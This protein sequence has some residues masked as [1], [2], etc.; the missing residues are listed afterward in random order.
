MGK[1]VDLTGK[2]F[3]RWMVMYRA[4]NRIDADGKTRVWFHCKCECGK[5]AD[6]NA[7]SLRNGKS[8]SCGCAR[9]EH[10]RGNHANRV[11]GQKGTRLYSIWCNMNDRCYRRE[12]ERYHRYGGRGIKVCDEWRGKHGFQSFMEWAYK[13]GYSKALTL[14]RIDNDRG[15]SPQNCRWASPKEQ[16]NNRSNGRYITV[17]EVRQ[18]VAQWSDQL[19]LKRPGIY[20]KSDEEIAALIQKALGY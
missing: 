13:S 6:V 8:L 19:G 15:Y 11:H 9:I 20:K 5:E 10:V 18:T 7:A 3:G 1:L 17:G 14:D 2:T 12:N 4:P 16:S